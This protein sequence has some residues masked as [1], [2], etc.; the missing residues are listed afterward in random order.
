[1]ERIVTKTIR[2]MGEGLKE[3]E[4]PGDFDRRNMAMEA[5]ISWSQVEDA[6]NDQLPDGYYAKLED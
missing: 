5:D 6:V 1:M 3:N 2:I 4:N